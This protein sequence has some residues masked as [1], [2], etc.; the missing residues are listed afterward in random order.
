M[1]LLINLFYMT[2]KAKKVEVTFRYFRFEEFEKDEYGQPKHLSNS[3]LRHITSLMT[4]ADPE[5]LSE[6]GTELSNNVLLN[7]MDSIVEN[8]TEED[9][10]K[11]EDGYYIIFCSMSNYTITTKVNKEA[12]MNRYKHTKIVDGKLDKEGDEELYLQPESK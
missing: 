10:E 8:M 7:L 9:V 4:Y 5:E 6:E 12:V 1:S 3:L 11:F 2:K